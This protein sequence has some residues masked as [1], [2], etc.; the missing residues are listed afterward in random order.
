MTR[1]EQRKA[2]FKARQQREL[3]ARKAALNKTPLTPEFLSYIIGFQVL[4]SHIELCLQ[5]INNPIEIVITNIRTVQSVIRSLSPNIR[6]LGCYYLFNTLGSYVGQSIKIHERVYG[7]LRGATSIKSIVQGTSTNQPINL[8]VYI[9]P[10]GVSLG[11]IDIRQFICLLEYMLM[12]KFFPTANISFLPTP[13]PSP[14]AST[15]EKISRR[16]KPVYMY[17]ISGGVEVLI[18]TFLSANVIGPLLGFSTHWGYHVLHHMMG[19]YKATV[20]V[21]QTMLKNRA[22]S[23]I[24]N[25]EI[26][27]ILKNTPAVSH[28]NTCVAVNNLS[29]GGVEI[30]NI[31][32]AILIFNVSIQ[33]VLLG[34]EIVLNGVT[35]KLSVVPNTVKT[36][37][38]INAKAQTS[39]EPTT[40]TSKPLFIYIVI[41]GV[42]T[43][44]YKFDAMNIVGPSLGFHKHYASR[45]IIN[46]K[47]WY[48]NVL[49]FTK[50]EI[51]NA[52]VALVSLET[53]KDMVKTHYSWS[54]T[55]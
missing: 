26:S 46:H 27:S 38:P 5:I 50:T 1:Q 33:S 28:T 21:S 23:P 45:V 43:L 24:S 12:H 15:I 29:T 14:T 11:G 25:D 54:Q 7:H 16:G 3:D 34:V 19:L 40:P 48:R 47:G 52:P 4:K 35:Y 8:F 44:V 55:K 2:L 30:I 6:L 31:L 39:F 37:G 9:V 49:F 22:N 51:V 32:E 42:L 36:A 20:F 17:L 18:H 53:L 10:E 13:G 41:N